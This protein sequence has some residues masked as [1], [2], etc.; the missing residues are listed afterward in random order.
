MDHT[1][2]ILGAF[3]MIDFFQELTRKDKGYWR[4]FGAFY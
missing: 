3:E 4:F 1:H 2:N